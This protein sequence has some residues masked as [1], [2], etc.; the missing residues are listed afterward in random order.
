MLDER[1]TAKMHITYLSCLHQP[2]T[3]C[4]HASTSEAWDSTP[5]CGRWK[6]W[7]SKAW[8]MGFTATIYCTISKIRKA[9]TGMAWEHDRTSV[10]NRA[11]PCIVNFITKWS[12]ELRVPG[13]C[14]MILRIDVATHSHYITLH[15]DFPLHRFSLKSTSSI[16]QICISMSAGASPTPIF[17]V[18]HWAWHFCQG[19]KRALDTKASWKCLD[20][21]FVVPDPKNW[22]GS[23][24]AI[25]H[26][27]LS[28]KACAMAEAE[29]LGGLAQP[30]GPMHYLYLFMDPELTV[31]L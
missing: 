7:P 26:S 25:D 27:G 8:A 13:S 5:I 15:N 20:F 23:G 17:G 28:S 30:R 3:L 18:C 21:G 11:S 29:G 9:W 19:E 10:L 4:F 31:A 6:A 16:T 1:E 12:E 2:W 14:C 22:L 24:R